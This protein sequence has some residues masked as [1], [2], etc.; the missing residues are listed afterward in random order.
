VGGVTPHRRRGSGRQPYFQIAPATRQGGNNVDDSRIMTFSNGVV[1]RSESTVP[2]LLG[3][4]RHD[5]Q[6]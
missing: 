4:C 5:V 3:N 1:E 2:L 6:E